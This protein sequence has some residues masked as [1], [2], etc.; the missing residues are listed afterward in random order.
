[1]TNSLI[2]SVCPRL[3]LRARGLNA[4]IFGAV[5]SAL[6]TGGTGR[7]GVDGGVT[8]EPG[9]VGAGSGVTAGAATVTLWLTSVLTCPCGSRA[10]TTTVITSPASPWPA[11][12]RSN[13]APVAPSIAT[14]LT[15]H[16]YW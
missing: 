3:Y 6:A 4:T 13:V 14:P 16:W 9:P 11:A 7:T 8:T 10:D 2:F 12:E 5:L 1:M 15:F